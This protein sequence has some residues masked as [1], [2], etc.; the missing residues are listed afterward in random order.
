MPVAPLL[1]VAL[2]ALLVLVT[3]GGAAVWAQHPPVMRAADGKSADF[4]SCTQCHA[5]KAKGP[6]I[7]AALQIGCSACHGVTQE[8]DRTN[9]VLT[10]D[11]NDLCFTCHDDKRPNPTS[12]FGHS[13]IRKEC[14]TLCHDPHSSSSPRLLRLPADVLEAGKN[15]CLGCHKNIEAQ[16]NKRNRHAAVDTGC[17]TC[18]E[19]H[20]S[21]PSGTAQS[22]FHLAKPQPELCLECHD[23]TDKSLQTAHLKQPFEKA[24]CTEC[25]NPHGSDQAKLLNNYVHPPFAEKQCDLCH[26]AAKDGRVV[27]SEGARRDLCLTCHSNIQERMEQAKFKH[28]PLSSDAGCVSCHSPHAAT[29]PHQIRRDPVALCLNCHSDQARARATKAHLHAPVFSMSCLICH[30]EHGGDRPRRLR[31]ETNTLCLECHGQQA[32][33]IVQAT[34][35]VELFGGKVK[36]PAKPFN[37]IRWL[38]L[39]ADGKRGHPF[40]NHPVSEEPEKGKPAI[41]CLTCHLPHAADGNQALLVT[42]QASESTLCVRCHK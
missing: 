4:E 10:T 26:E 22:T 36:L 41:N 23:A 14:C 16:I 18:H 13:P 34:G 37:D 1:R 15:L 11:G 7:H 28:A 39:G 12:L 42:E 40:A 31:A 19:T 29:Y 38:Q 5:E 8:D 33:K 3:S 2:F 32:I 30:E 9:V 24:R 20:R 21:E 27:L 17:S 25:H 6:T 35:P